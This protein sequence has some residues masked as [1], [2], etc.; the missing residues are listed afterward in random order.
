MMRKDGKTASY[1]SQEDLDAVVA[2]ADVEK[3]G[4]MNERGKA[5]KRSY[6]T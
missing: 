3:G 5:M 1:V 6:Y 4:R 2:D